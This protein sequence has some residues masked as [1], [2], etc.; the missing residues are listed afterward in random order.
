MVVN[1]SLAFNWRDLVLDFHC[2]VGL[3][4]VVVDTCWGYLG[5][6]SFS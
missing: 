3:T 1:Y 4:I 2:L 5:G 6:F